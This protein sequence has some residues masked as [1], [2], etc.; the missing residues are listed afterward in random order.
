[1]QHVFP[2]YYKKFKCINKK[3]R[4]NCCIGWEI[5]IDSET[6]ARYG[7]VGGEMGK[8]LSK[9]ISRD[10][11]AH[12]ILSD[13]ERCPFLNSENLCD[14]ILTLGEESLCTICREHPRF[15]NSLPGR[16]ESGLGLC[17]EE[18]ARIIIGQVE[19]T[20]LEIFGE[21]DYYDEIIDL[22]DRVILVL[23]DRSRPISERIRNMLDLCGASLPQKTAEE[24]CDIFLSLESLDTK[25]T[26]MLTLL[27][28]EHKSIDLA[29]FDRHMS[30]RQSEYEQLAVYIIYRYFANS[31]DIS[32]ASVAAS[33]ASLCYSLIRTLGALIYT[34]TKKFD[35]EDHIE[36]IR[37]FSC[38]IEYSSENIDALFDILT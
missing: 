33:F 24:W 18:A 8:R 29:A 34:K 35:F 15:H 30:E 10:G 27:R 22:R 3:C 36:L 28:S 11:E 14:I 16:I 4:H 23:Q 13:G 12:F 20:L 1:M 25:W 5:D 38:E 9:S 37:M 2:S 26:N 19:P 31:F 7:S 32:E 6:L 21:S 17:C